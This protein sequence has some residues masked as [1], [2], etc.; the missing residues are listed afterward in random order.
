M[1]VKRITIEYEDGTSEVLTPAEWMG[2]MLGTRSGESSVPLLSDN[3]T[4]SSSVS[5]AHETF[6]SAQNLV[7]AVEEEEIVVQIEPLPVPLS[8]G[9]ED[10][11]LV[12]TDASVYT[13][14]VREEL[15]ESKP[16]PEDQK[17]YYAATVL[18][19]P[20]GKYKGRSI[21]ELVLDDSEFALKC[22]K[23]LGDNGKHRE[24]ANAIRLVLS[25]NP[26]I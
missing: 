4:N 5:F 24:L 1:T 19:F 23:Q 10:T 20:F 9:S 25:K 12:S 11:E 3:T 22:A 16:V 21:L 7:S 15:E 6:Q 8:E 17:S 14:P 18:R 26:G 2:V 13:S